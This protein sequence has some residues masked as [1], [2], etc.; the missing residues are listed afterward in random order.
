LQYEIANFF[1]EQKYITK[2]FILAP[3][4]I[5]DSYL[6]YNFL[7][8]HK[9]FTP[10]NPKTLAPDKKKVPISDYYQGTH[11]SIK[12]I[13]LKIKARKISKR[14]VDV[15]KKP[16]ISLFIKNFSNNKNNHINFQVRQTRDL[17]KIERIIY[18]L[19]KKNFNVIILGTEKDHFIQLFSKKI[20]KNKEILKNI[21]L[22][23]D[24]SNNYSIA[25]Q[26]Y[27]ALNSIG[28]IGSASGAMGFFGLLNKK[29]I[30]IDYVF[31]YANK[32]WKDFYFLYKK[33]YN[34]KNRTLKKYIWQKY[35]D[36]SIYKIV[37]VSFK[38][39]KNVLVKKILNKQ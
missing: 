14:I 15:L 39:I 9:I 17:N 34:T 12:F 16:T 2:S 32:Y 21:F 30:F 36:P 4:F 33:I 37:E 24:L 3:R 22:F 11:S 13:T 26:A 25:D 23:K 31:F 35:Y 19:N 6:G 5:S 7:D 8:K 29:V 1:F 38:D 10:T 20:Y 28:Y 18:F 27:V